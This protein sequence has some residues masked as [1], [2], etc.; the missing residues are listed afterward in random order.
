MPKIR[1]QSLNLKEITKWKTLRN[2]RQDC[3][4]K[5]SLCYLTSLKLAT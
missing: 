5:V 3:K 4:F 1:T 2:L